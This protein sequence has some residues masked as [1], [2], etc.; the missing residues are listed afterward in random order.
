[1]NYFARLAQHSGIAR[2]RDAV[3]PAVVTPEAPSAPAVAPIEQDVAIVTPARLPAAP[4]ETDSVLREEDDV[5]AAR[6]PASS[7]RDREPSM[8]AGSASTA[9]VVSDPASVSAPL[10]PGAPERQAA[11]ATPTPTAAAASEVEVIV[12]TNTAPA[13]STA[14]AGSAAS[15]QRASPPRSDAPS[16]EPPPIHEVVETTAARVVPIGRVTRDARGEKSSCSGPVE[17]RIGTVTL[18]VHAA[19]S[20]APAPAGNSFAPHR[21]YLRLW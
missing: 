5:G 6:A 17:V 19:P 10:S 7:S 13:P 21:H 15:D 16:T 12:P 4:G 3:A 14:A 9:E 18:Q 11:E 8:S 20:P 1:M 2:P